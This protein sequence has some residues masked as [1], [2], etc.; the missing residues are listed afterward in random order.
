MSGGPYHAAEFPQGA[1]SWARRGTLFPSVLVLAAACQSSRVTW[2]EVSGPSMAETLLGPHARMTCPACGWTLRWDTSGGDPPAS[3]VCQNC[4]AKVAATGAAPIAGKRVRLTPR[5]PRDSRYPRGKIVVARV[6]GGLTVK[7]I[8][9]LPGEQIR[10]HGGDVFVNDKR[11]SKSLDEFRDR[12]RLLHDDTF[13]AMKGPLAGSWWKRG[14]ESQWRETERGFSWRS[15][16]PGAPLTTGMEPGGGDT[17]EFRPRI[18]YLGPKRG[19]EGPLSDSSTYNA[20]LSRLVHSPRDVMLQVRISNL[21]G[22]VT[23]VC[24]YGGSVWELL[25]QEAPRPS[26]CELRRVDPPGART[27]VELEWPSPH[28]AP[29]SKVGRE[30][31]IGGL[32]GRFLVEWDRTLLFENSIHGDSSQAGGMQPPRETG[33][34][35]QVPPWSWI[36]GGSGSVDLTDLR[37]WCDVEYLDP[38]EEGT[39]QADGVALGA[40]EYFLLGDNGMNSQDGHLG[41]EYGVI[42]GEEVLGTLETVGYP[43]TQ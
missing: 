1:M 2:I 6:R 32:D 16:S 29:Q 13:R 21:R 24:H 3:G 19:E 25:L 35:V 33:R 5:N 36:A 10:I 23:L 11:L 30:L 34:L 7:R 8:V 26:R 38:T 41:R 18:N 12:A 20:G 14:P 37:I 43:R 40:D 4:A 31:W 28:P 27:E 42:R 39:G 22:M 9:G 15:E 17:L